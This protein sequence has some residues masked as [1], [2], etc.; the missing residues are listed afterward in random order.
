MNE[1]ETVTEQKSLCRDCERMEIVKERYV[2]PANATVK[3]WYC[4]KRKLLIRNETD[5]AIRCLTYLKR[6]V[7]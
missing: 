3:Y 5:L 7:K 1:M 4:V 6:K 2:Y